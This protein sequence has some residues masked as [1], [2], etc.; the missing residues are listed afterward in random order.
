MYTQT[1]PSSQVASQAAS[2]K[3]ANPPPFAARTQ[4]PKKNE[5]WGTPPPRAWLEINL[6]IIQENFRIISRAVAPLSVISVVKANA[7]GLGARPIAASLCAAGTERLGVATV[8]EAMEIS[9]STCPIQLLGTLQTAE[10]PH[11][12]M[13][14]IICPVTGRKDAERLNKEAQAQGRRVPVEILVDSGMRRLGVQLAE[15]VEL[16]LYSASLNNLDVQ[17]IYSH[18]PSASTDPGGSREQVRLFLT[19]LDQIRQKGLVLPSVHLANSDGIHF[20]PEACRS[21]FT[22]VRTGLNLYGRSDLKTAKL[23]GL[24]D[25][26]TLK[27]RLLAI[28]DLPVGAS[29]GYDGTHQ[30]SRATRV[31]TIGIGYADGFPLALSNQGTVLLRGRPCPVLG[32]VSMDYVMIDLSAIPEARVDEEVTCLGG[33]ISLC[34]WATLANSIPYEILCS[35]GP[36]V[37]RRY[38]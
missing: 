15:A 32:R 21:P 20:I 24:H 28:R 26:F 35:L 17:G 4:A 33:N 34:D 11:A 36:R 27:T 1:E 30:L 18:F 2:P 3:T 25:V 23:P 14:G 29:I 9:D 38:L 7:Y 16:V 5:K 22:A 6:P 31:G 8:A 19:L 37:Q 13:H 12:V 10:I